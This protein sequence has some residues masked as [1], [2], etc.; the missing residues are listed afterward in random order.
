MRVIK[1]RQELQVEDYNIKQ[2]ALC[3]RQ[4]IE[5]WKCKTSATRLD[6]AA[7][8]STKIT[9]F[10]ISVMVTSK[11]TMA[12]AFDSTKNSKCTLK[13]TI[14]YMWVQ[15]QISWKMCDRD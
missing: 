12:P 6:I 4:N 2:S 14:T 7:I 10:N 9:L 13:S 3:R 1:D 8:E 11:K 15:S 5:G